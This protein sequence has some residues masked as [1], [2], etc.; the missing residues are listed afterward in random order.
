[1]KTKSKTLKKLIL[2]LIL[3]TCLYFI[4]NTVKGPTRL[5]RQDGVLEVKGDYANIFEAVDPTTKLVIR[6]NLNITRL[7]TIYLDR[8]PDGLQTV[9]W[10]ENNIWAW[11]V[12][13]HLRSNHPT[14]FQDFV[15]TYIFLACI[16]ISLILSVCFAK[17]VMD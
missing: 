15:G 4:Y 5:C 2:S 14:D 8:G 16:S 3:G 6:R 9:E 17:W 10:K 12:V 13:Y 11:D 7:P 1:M